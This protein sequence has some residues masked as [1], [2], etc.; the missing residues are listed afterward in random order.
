[1]R[2]T[3]VILLIFT[4]LLAACVRP[5]PAT[6]PAATTAAP[7]DS[8]AGPYPVVTL[9]PPP[10]NTP[11]PTSPPE[12]P[13]S[14]PPEQ[15]TAAPT[16]P[17]ATPGDVVTATEAPAATATTAPTQTPAA[18]P[19]A[20]LP[21]F[22]PSAALGPPDFRDPMKQ[23][24]E[25]NWEGETGSLPDTDNIKLV[26]D[27]ERLE[28]TGKKQFFDTW[29][30][31]WPVLDDFFLEM[32]VTTGNCSGRDAYG[33]ILRGPLRGTGNTWGYIVSFSCDGSLLVRRV[34]DADPYTVVDLIPWT[35]NT[36]IKAGSQKTNTLGI[37]ANGD[38]LTIYANNFQIATIVDTRYADGRYGVFVSAAQTA[39]F[40]YEVDEI[41]YW[42]LDK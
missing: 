42:D 39:S 3:Y 5:A 12:E 1:M 26:L 20:T 6:T 34:D 16:E 24:S 29:W 21:P 40:T 37:E 15:A 33:V 9:T 22:D 8:Q 31:S 36:N 25:I 17:P 14:A 13:T 41:R 32:D 4:L 2:K 19:T 18:S 28:V 27:G 23:F 30:F 35:A 7:G 10:T 11:L 38:T